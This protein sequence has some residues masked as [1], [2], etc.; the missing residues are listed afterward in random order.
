MSTNFVNP[1]YIESIKGTK[2]SLGAQDYHFT[3]NGAFTVSQALIY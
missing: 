3:Q 2:I 1:T